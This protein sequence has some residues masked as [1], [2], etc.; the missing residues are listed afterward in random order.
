MLGGYAVIVVILEIKTWFK[1]KQ[2]E[3]DKSANK[4]DKLSA[5]TT[6]HDSGILTSEEFE[7]KKALIGEVS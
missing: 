2:Y 3:K 6:L 5:L 4:N 1:S 7:S